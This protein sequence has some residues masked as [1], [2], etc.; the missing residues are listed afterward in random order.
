MQNQ[1]LPH[2]HTQ[3]VLIQNIIHT[4]P[5]ADQKWYMPNQQTLQYEDIIKAQMILLN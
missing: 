3:G 5:T 2:T 1:Q 4:D